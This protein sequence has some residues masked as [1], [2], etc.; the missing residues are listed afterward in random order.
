MRNLSP[1]NDSFPKKSEIYIE[2]KNNNFPE[3]Y[4]QITITIPKASQSCT[5]STSDNSSN[6]SATSVQS[7]SHSPRFSQDRSSRSI[8]QTP[9]INNYQQE[10]Q[11]LISEMQNLK[12]ADILSER[13]MDFPLPT[14]EI[15]KKNVDLETKLSLNNKNNKL[16]LL[17][18]EFPLIEP[19]ESVKLV[20]EAI[21]ISE[22]AYP[23][24]ETNNV[25]KKND[26]NS[27]LNTTNMENKRLF[28]DEVPICNECKRKI[29]RYFYVFFSIEIVVRFTLIKLTLSTM[30]VLLHGDRFHYV[31]EDHSSPHWEKFG[32]Q[33]TLF[34]QRHLVEDLFKIWVSLKNKASCIASIVSSN[35]WLPFARNVTQRSK[36]YVIIL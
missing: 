9:W 2:V 36:G 8:S 14:M 35:I 10:N 15:S 5:L 18:T 17:E 11:D 30:H 16:G 20:N 33:T 34:A 4:D 6:N 13:N 22:S 12:I 27:E 32:V 29:V 24:N 3:P 23:K 7:G 21:K 25:I 31:S 26:E 28:K 19:L 1:T